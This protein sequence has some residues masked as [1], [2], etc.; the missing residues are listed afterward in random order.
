MHI[1]EAARNLMR[2]RRLSRAGLPEKD[3]TALGSGIIHPI[4]DEVEE[5]RACSRKTALFGYESRAC[6]IWDFS[7]CRIYLCGNR[8]VNGSQGIKRTYRRR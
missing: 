7:N 6:T 5:S 2:N 4:G 1:I 3:E 8:Q